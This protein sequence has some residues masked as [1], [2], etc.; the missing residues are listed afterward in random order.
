MFRSI[1]LLLLPN[2]HH[3]RRM[4]KPKWAIVV[5]VVVATRCQGILPGSEC[6]GFGRARKDFELWYSVL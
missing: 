2:H 6:A 4:M 5:V 3:R 1:L